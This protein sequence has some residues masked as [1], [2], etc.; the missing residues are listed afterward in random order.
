MRRRPEVYGLD[1]ET[2][3]TTNGLDPSVARV[4]TVALSCRTHDEVFTGEEPSL[5]IELDARLAQLQPG[6]IATWN[7][8]AF[9]LPFL[10]DRAG[11]CGVQLG[12]RT[13]LDPTITMR[14]AP[15]PGH[16][17]AYRARWHGHDHI[18]AY[19]LY[20][21]DTGRAW[22][23]CSLRSFARLVGLAPLEVRQERTQ[24]LSREARHAHASSGAR[25][26]RVL[27]ERRWARASRFTDRLSPTTTAPT[28]VTPI[29]TG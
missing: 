25:L 19:R 26:A 2:D 23:S 7:G 16:R 27:A 24:D 17:G 5:L 4:L 6:V 22:L 13:V 10:A 8:A 21:G 29:L 14:R 3:T 1:I 9:D 11:R 28:G 15:L 12:L 20:R 18:D